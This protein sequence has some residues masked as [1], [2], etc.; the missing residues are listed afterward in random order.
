MKHFK[1][2]L[3][4]LFVVFATISCKK[5]TLDPATTAAGTTQA[6]KAPMRLPIV[7]YM[8]K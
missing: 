4:A 7:G 1:I 2:K 5:D 8:T 6:Q 3:F